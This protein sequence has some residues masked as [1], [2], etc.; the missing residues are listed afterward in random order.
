MSTWPCT[1]CTYANHASKRR[2]ALCLTPKPP[3]SGQ[4]SNG[5]SSHN[6]HV[7]P[8][9]EK[10]DPQYPFGKVP[11]CSMVPPHILFEP[12]NKPPSDQSIFERWMVAQLQ[13]KSG[14]QPSICIE[15]G[16]I[17][18]NLRRVRGPTTCKSIQQQINN[19]T[20]AMKH[21]GNLEAGDF[22]DD[23]EDE[24]SMCVP[25]PR[26][27][28]HSSTINFI[29]SLN[30]DGL[31]PATRIHHGHSHSAHSKLFDRVTRPHQSHN[32]HDFGSSFKYK[33][34]R[35]H[36]NKHNHT[37]AQL[38]FKAQS[39]LKQGRNPPL[40]TKYNITLTN[41]RQHNPRFKD[42]Q[43][44]KSDHEK[45]ASYLNA[46]AAQ[47]LTQNDAQRS[48]ITKD[49]DDE[50]ETDYD[51]IDVDFDEDGSVEYESNSSPYA[52]PNGYDPSLFVE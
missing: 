17:L 12:L 15:N 16:V 40:L 34:R 41:I 9:N 28:Q 29:P 22:T 11:Q 43:R 3:P 52:H 23:E 27:I 25:S 13:C 35:K 30:E 45:A 33:Q 20:N 7:A 49:E 46:T 2:C 24:L 38:W 47:K 14:E 26:S 44:R 21:P 4:V 18:S 42:Y 5:H 10:D 51:D 50:Y 6:G 32:S 8:L 48:A 37:V 19:N 36:R 39:Q 31:P 1:E